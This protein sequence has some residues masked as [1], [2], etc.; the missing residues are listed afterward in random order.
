MSVKAFS[1][2]RFVTAAGTVFTL[3]LLEAMFPVS[4]A[5]AQAAAADPRRYVGIYF[6]NGT[7]NQPTKPIW[8]PPTGLL[9]ATNTS[10]VLSPFAAYYPKFSILKAIK[11][12]SRNAVDSYTQDEHEAGAV[13]YFTCG[14]QYPLPASVSS[15]DQVIADKTGKPAY[16]LFGGVTDF[17]E[18]GDEFVSF[19]NG[20]GIRGLSNPGDLYRDLLNKVVPSTGG[21]TPVT[22]VDNSGKKSVLDSSM[23]DLSAL[24]AKLGKNDRV[25]LDEYLASVR[26]LETKLLAA[27]PPV[28]TGPMG[29]GCVKPTIAANVDTTNTTNASL[30][31]PR[32]F[33]FNDLIKI[34]FAC[35]IS[36]S[37]CIMVDTETTTRTFAPAPANLI[38]NGVDI[39]GGLES[40]IAISHRAGSSNGKDG[41][42]PNGVARCVTRDR[43]NFSIIAD[44]ISK[45]STGTDP[46]GSPIL[47]NTII[48]AGFGFNDGMHSYYNTD[49]VPLVVAG[50]KNFMNPGRSFDVGGYDMSDLYFTFNKLLNLGLTG[51]QGGTKTIPL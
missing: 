32:F 42:D 44:L 26:A 45:L 25:K 30:Y 8:Y 6:P 41:A 5:L 16:V 47:D 27:P 17:D 19:R 46:S 9:S 34:V 18:P 49:V 13:S 28:P 12:S 2:R 1:R 21:T 50:G 20:K 7:Y 35:D 10:D 23:A 29:S 40:H 43:V 36:R 38:Y 4:R 39:G 15:F 31:L 14:K 48:Q 37:V 51:F 11:H 22:P 33:A 24:K 3:P